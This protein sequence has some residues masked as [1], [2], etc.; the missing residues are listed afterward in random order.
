MVILVTWEDQ[1]VEAS[2]ANTT[3]T[4]KQFIVLL[5]C[6]CGLESH[7][8]VNRISQSGSGKDRGLKW[9]M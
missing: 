3:K 9:G 2:L 5:C 8:S 6:M 1:E 4:I 7:S